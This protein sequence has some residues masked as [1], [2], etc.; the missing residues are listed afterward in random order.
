RRGPGHDWSVVRLGIAGRIHRIE[1]STAHY[2][3]NYP[4][5]ATVEAAV[6]PD[7]TRGVSADTATRAIAHWNTVLP[8]T[9]LQPDHVHVFER[10]LAPDVAASHVRLNI[11][12]DGG[13]SR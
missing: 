12:P 3:G 2:K 9:K 11:F 10:E 5:S 4:D 8:D 1:L 13:V 7:D 6:V